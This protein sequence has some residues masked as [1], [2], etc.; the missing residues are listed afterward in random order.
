MLLELDVARDNAFKGVASTL[1]LRESV[2]IMLCSAVMN[3]WHN[4]CTA[5]LYNCCVFWEFRFQVSL[6]V[7]GFGEDNDALSWL[8]FYARPAIAYGLLFLASGG[9]AGARALAR[10]IR[11]GPE[12]GRRRDR[13][14]ASA[15]RP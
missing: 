9:S 11:G 6:N 8:S 13:I 5:I 14:R 10:G 7:V 2:K 3:R 15:I 4:A 12:R 1:Y